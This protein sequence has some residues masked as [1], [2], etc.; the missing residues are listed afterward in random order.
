MIMSYNIE[1]QPIKASTIWQR[2]ARATLD[3]A[4]ES[5]LKLVT[6][7]IEVAGVKYVQDVSWTRYRTSSEAAEAIY[8]NVRISLTLSL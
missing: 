7:P 1:L 2:I 8:L 6:Y 3:L 4:M 5:A